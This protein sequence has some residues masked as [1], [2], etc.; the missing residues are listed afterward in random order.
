MGSNLTSQVATGIF[1]KQV[2]HMIKI[3]C[4]Q[5]SVIIGLVLS[6]V[7]L[8]VFI[9]SNSNDSASSTANNINSYNLD[10]Q[11]KNILNDFIKHQVKNDED[12]VEGMKVFKGQG[13]FEA[14]KKRAM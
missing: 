3:P 13:G 9:I 8:N 14:S 10:D 4:Y 7:G 5:F 1:T 6:V 2:S 12:L 11:Y